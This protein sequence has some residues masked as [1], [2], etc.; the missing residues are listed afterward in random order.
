MCGRIGGSSDMHQTRIGEADET[1]QLA[2]AE[3]TAAESQWFADMFI[4][5]HLV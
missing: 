3:Q 2:A 5:M 4:W 1:N